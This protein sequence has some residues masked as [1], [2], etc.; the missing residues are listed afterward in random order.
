VEGALRRG[1]AV[2][3]TDVGDLGRLADAANA[4]LRLLTPGK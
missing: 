1:D 3:T 2:V 4:P